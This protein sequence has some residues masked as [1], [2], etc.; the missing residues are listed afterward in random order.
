MFMVFSFAAE[1]SWSFSIPDIVPRYLL[2][3]VTENIPTETRKAAII[4][5]LFVILFPLNFY[6]MPFSGLPYK[7]KRESKFDS[8]LPGYNRLRSVR[9]YSGANP[10]NYKD[11]TTLVLQRT[12]LSVRA[13]RPSQQ[14]AL[15]GFLLHAL[16]SIFYAIPGQGRVF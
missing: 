15:S 7:Q 9:G 2:A 3:W 10:P 14:W 16:R 12:L 5:S 6:I 4:L 8:A 13:F 11:T 1:K